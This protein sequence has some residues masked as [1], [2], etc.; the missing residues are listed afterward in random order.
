MGYEK[1]FHCFH[2]TTEEAYNQ[3]VQNEKFTFQ[4]RENHWLGNGDQHQNQFL[5]PINP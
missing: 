2:G 4:T 5:N 1:T 3:I